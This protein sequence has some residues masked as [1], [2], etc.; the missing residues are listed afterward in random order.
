MKIRY[1]KDADALY[2]KFA[3]SKYT[4]SDEIAEGVIVDYNKSNKVIGIEFLHA[5]KT[6]FKDALKTIDLKALQA[7]A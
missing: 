7:K 5:S 3:K 4:E 6:F 2:I 1:D